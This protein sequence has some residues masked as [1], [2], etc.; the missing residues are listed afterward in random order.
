MLWLA[1]Q[2][3]YSQVGEFSPEQGIVSIHSR[4]ELES[5][6]PRSIDGKF[7]ATQG[8][9]FALY[10]LDNTLHF[11]ANGNN[12]TLDD[13]T[14][15]EVLGPRGMR[16]LWVMQCGQV[17]FDTTYKPE[18]LGMIPGDPTPM[19]EEEDFDFGLWASNVSRNPERKAVALEV[20]GMDR[21]QK[22]GV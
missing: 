8:R 2:H 13:D 10:K 22:N 15:I 16:S 6:S 4:D 1:R 17:A 3:A 9:L 11:Y 19:V 21:N 14:V 5:L 18:G 12:F 7:Y 20:W